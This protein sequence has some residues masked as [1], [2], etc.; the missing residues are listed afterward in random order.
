MTHQ[1]VRTL[2]KLQV[3]T[4]LVALPFTKME[5]QDKPSDSRAML[6]FQSKHQLGHSENCPFSLSVKSIFCIKVSK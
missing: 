6:L 4:L 3:L 5:Q 2:F 1:A